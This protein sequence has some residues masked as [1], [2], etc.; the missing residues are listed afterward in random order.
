M[1]ARQLS[2]CSDSCLAQPGLDSLLAGRDAQSHQ[3]IETDVTWGNWTTRDA[4]LPAALPSFSPGN[5]S[6]GSLLMHLK[7]SHSL[8][9]NGPS[10]RDWRFRKD[11]PAVEDRF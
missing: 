8:Q 5:G 9:I 10:S 1:S 3:V 4:A 7:R 6:H 11:I 2:A